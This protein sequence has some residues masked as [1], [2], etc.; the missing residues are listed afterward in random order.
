[1]ERAVIKR[2]VMV[3]SL[4]LMVSVRA[5]AQIERPVAE[6]TVSGRVSSVTGAP[7]S[8]AAITVVGSKSATRTDSAGGFR[9]AR[10]PNDIVTIEFHR[11][12]FV[13]AM[14]TLDATKGTDT[15]F[16]Q[17]L[18]NTPTVDTF[19]VTA[20]T[21]LLA[22]IVLDAQNQPVSGALIT[23]V[24]R[25]ALE[26]E[27][28]ADGW[29]T[30]SI[31]RPGPI[32]FRVKKPGFASLTES[33]RLDGVRG[34]VL[35]LL[36][37]SANLTRIQKSDADGY[38]NRMVF[39]WHQTDHRMAVK[40]SRAAIVPR[41]ELAPLGS[42]PLGNAIRFTKSGR[43]AANFLTSQGNDACILLDGY[44]PMGLTSLDIYKAS[45]VEFVELYPPGS[46]MSGSLEGY[47]SITVCNDPLKKRDP[48]P[49][50]A[51]VWM[52]LQN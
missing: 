8:G 20:T 15:L 46:E 1:M 43:G 10:V 24:G 50:Y 48:R 47:L 14:V 29:F 21:N 36:K 13:P 2:I 7:I 35:H 40:S 23:L 5:R 6:I 44:R 39:V 4:F 52:R 22:G 19:K 16:V 38:N 32:V 3:A 31:E 28:G 11:L 27:S 33:L 17:M 25:K 30:F 37:P 34:V 45:D 41:E 51:V 26:L 12:G 9:L 18:A 42:M 49:Y